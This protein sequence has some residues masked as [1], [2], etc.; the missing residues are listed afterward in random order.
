MYITDVV[1]KEIF[2]YVNK[3]FTFFEQ[4]EREIRVGE[5]EKRGQKRDRERKNKYLISNGL[6]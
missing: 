3:P 2:S 5:R 1:W 6:I 4:A